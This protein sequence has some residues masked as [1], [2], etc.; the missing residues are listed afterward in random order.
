MAQKADAELVRYCF[1]MADRIGGMMENPF[2]KSIREQFERGRGLSMKQFGILAKAVGE[3]AGSLPDCETVREKLSEF[4]AGG[5]GNRESDPAIP[6]L[7]AIF[8][9]VTEWRPA[10]KKGKKVYDDKEF[11]KSLGEQFSRRHSLSQ[12]QVAALKRVIG[13]YKERIPDYAAKAA[14]LGLDAADG[15][16]S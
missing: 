3:N 6:G 7:L 1:E 12:R 9:G 4:V 14:A 8:D 2:Y 13:A 5:F 11:V 10:V 15:K 16:K